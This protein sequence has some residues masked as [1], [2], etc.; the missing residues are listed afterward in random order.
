ML[1]IEITNIL[2]SRY[3]SIWINQRR[4]QQAKSN[5][6]HDT[7]PDDWLPALDWPA[8]K[9]NTD[10]KSSHDQ[11][12]SNCQSG[13]THPLPVFAVRVDKLRDPDFKFLTS[14]PATLDSQHFFM[15]I[16]PDKRI[17]PLIA[18]SSRFAIGTLLVTILARRQLKNRSLAFQ[19]DFTTAHQI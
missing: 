7:G 18:N 10:Y 13:I 6:K 1:S 16:I 9:T 17:N 12:Y 11:Q 4:K 5:I 15:S 14:I 19:L 8:A 2:F 3:I